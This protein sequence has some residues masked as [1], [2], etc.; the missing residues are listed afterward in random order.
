M[1]TAQNEKENPNISGDVQIGSKDALYLLFRDDQFEID[2]LNKQHRIMRDHCGGNFDAPIQE[3]L[4]QGISVLDAGC[5]TG[6]WTVDMSKRYPQSTFEGIDISP[7]FAHVKSKP[8]NC[9]FKT[10]D[11]TQPF[12]FPDN[13]FDYVHQRFLIAGIPEKEWQTVVN[14]VMRVV[15][16]GGYVELME[17]VIP[18]ISNCGPKF[19]L[20][21]DSVKEGS[22]EK[23]IRLT[24]SRELEQ[25]LI[26]AGAI[27]IRHRPIMFP[28][29]EHGE[30]GEFWGKNNFIPLFRHQFGGMVTERHPE[31][32]DPKKLDQFMEEVI[33]ECTE[34]KSE[35]LIYRFYAQK[36]HETL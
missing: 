29:G 25:Y 4:E 9:S 26:N 5:G 23:G 3:Q 20:L 36:P 28:L 12:P 10:Y 2:R 22:L 21:K 16:P 17:T 8:G 31:L 7:T 19:G 34:N 24:L 27:N 11:I 15:K 6:V 18:D 32:K 33:A 30:I 1:I 14:N 35:M 13:H